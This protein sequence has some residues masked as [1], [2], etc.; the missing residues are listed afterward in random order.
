MASSAVVSWGNPTAQLW[1]V[2]CGGRPASIE[3]AAV[4]GYVQDTVDISVDVH[5]MI[6]TMDGIDFLAF[7][8]RGGAEIALPLPQYL[9]I[10]GHAIVTIA[11]R[12]LPQD[13]SEL[14]VAR[15][16][17]DGLR[18][19]F[20]EGTTLLNQH[21]IEHYAIADRPANRTRLAALATK[22]LRTFAQDLRTVSD[23]CGH[24]WASPP[25][26]GASPSIKGPCSPHLSAYTSS[27]GLINT[28]VQQPSTALANAARVAAGKGDCRQWSRNGKCRFRDDCV[29]QHV[30]RPR[31]V[32]AGTQ[33]H[34]AADGGSTDGG[35][36]ATSASAE[37]GPAKW[38]KG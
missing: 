29:Y 12:G 21:V 28:D 10:L 19:A 26:V 32:A 36:A 2:M 16:R 8:P 22:D 27:G 13:A 38:T 3:K 31:K 7:T 5:R 4:Q 24:S 34:G 9:S 25:P 30:V 35:T 1:Q 6:E 15:A 14:P 37:D 18:H 23:I 20:C 17:M 33:R 11:S